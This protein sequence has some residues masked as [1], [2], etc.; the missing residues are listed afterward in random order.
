MPFISSTRSIFGP[1]GILGKA[2]T[3][4][5][6]QSDPGSSGLNIYNDYLSK[7]STPISGLY[8]INTSTGV[9]EVYCDMTTISPTDGKAGW[10]LVGSWNTSSNWSASAATSTSVFNTTAL[11]CFSANFGTM[12]MNYM[13]ILVSSDINNSATNATSCDFYFY[14]SST[15]NWR[16]RWVTDSNNNIRWSTTTNNGASTPREAMQQFNFA[17]NL[18]YSYQV[19][20]VWNN[21]SDGAQ[22][23]IIGRQGD[24]WNGLNGTTTSIGWRG[25]GDGSLAILPQGSSSTGAGQDCNENQTKIGYD[26]DQ[27]AAW[28]GTSA[29]A[30]L[31]NNVGTQG[32]N[33]NMWL[34]IK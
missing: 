4:K 25:A 19:N 17:Y 28:F 11:N 26:D 9:K 18:K 24:W 34:W 1:Q 8:Y 27:L 22:S 7:G 32:S 10:M 3:F 21:L 29:T 15:D 33:T 2:L 31:N 5:G 14:W 13:R 23:P 30:N 12:N 20:Q 16:T 6:T